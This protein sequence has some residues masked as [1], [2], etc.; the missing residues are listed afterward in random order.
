MPPSSLPQAVALLPLPPSKA[1]PAGGSRR[2]LLP[3]SHPP[4]WD[5]FSTASGAGPV[6]L[7]GP[8]A[9]R[10]R[11][12]DGHASLPRPAP[13]AR[14]ICSHLSRSLRCRKF[15]SAVN[16]HREASR[17]G[18]ACGSLPPAGPPSF[19]LL[20]VVINGWAPR[21]VDSFEKIDK[22]ACG[23]VTPRAWAGPVA[24]FGSTERLKWQ[25]FGFETAKSARTVNAANPVWQPGQKCTS[26]TVW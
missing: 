12:G 20:P 21:R 14:R 7:A 18:R 10:R 4:L 9:P 25:V 19:P 11:V 23:V 24:R 1:M 26:R 15:R 17:T 3:A 8:L 6:L 16:T 13:T 5:S 2:S 22:F